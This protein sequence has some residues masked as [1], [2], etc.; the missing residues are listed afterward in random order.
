MNFSMT[1][2][3]ITIVTLLEA[4]LPMFGI[5]LAEGQVSKAIEGII[6]CIGVVLMIYG[7]WRRPDVKY[8]IVKP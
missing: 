3:G 4:V 1:G 7:Q 2:I 6:T 5:E 8:G